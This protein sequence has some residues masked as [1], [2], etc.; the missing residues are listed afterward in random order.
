[1]RRHHDIELMT[2]PMGLTTLRLL[3]LPVF[4][5]VLLTDANS[6]AHRLRWLAVA[7]FAVMAITDKLDGYLARR[8]NQTSHLGTLLDP[9]ADKLLVACSVILL[10][11]AWVAPR[12]FKIPWYVVVAIYGKDVTVALGSLALLAILGKVRVT[13][14]LLGKL[15]TFLQLMMILATLIAP[16]IANLDFRFALRLTRGL[17]IAVTIVSAAA[18]VDYVVQGFVQLGASRKT[19]VV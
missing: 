16:D 7:I 18:C 5:Y 14:R 19:Q 6:E 8:L 1:M 15:G 3:L 12:G 9:L 10:S 17:W 11:F 4:L 2:W 13:P